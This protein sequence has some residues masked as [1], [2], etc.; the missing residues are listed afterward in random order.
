MKII[1]AVPK[2]VHFLSHVTCETKPVPNGFELGKSGDGKEKYNTKEIEI[3]NEDF[4]SEPD[5]DWHFICDIVALIEIN[6]TLNKNDRVQIEQHL[7]D[8]AN[9]GP[10]LIVLKVLRKY[11]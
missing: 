8:S 11:V 9:V 3:E 1:L 6:S 2:E 4:V 10:K 7:E 5:H